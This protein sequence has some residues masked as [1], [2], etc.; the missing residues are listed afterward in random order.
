[1]NLCREKEKREEVKNLDMKKVADKRA[2]NYSKCDMAIQKEQERLK[3]VF[4]KI[5]KRL[6]GISV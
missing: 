1:M 2:V 3:I 4:L 6:S 5:S